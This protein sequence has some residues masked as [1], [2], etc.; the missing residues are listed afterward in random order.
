MIDTM[1]WYLT[2]SALAGPVI[3]VF[4]NTVTVDGPLT[5]TVEGETVPLRDDGSGSDREA[6]DGYWTGTLDGPPGLGK[7]QPLEVH[8]GVGNSWSGGVEWDGSTPQRGQVGLERDGT[9]IKPPFPSPAVVP[10]MRSDGET[11]SEPS[12]APISSSSSSSSSS[13]DDS[14]GG[15]GWLLAALGWG[16]FIASVLRQVRVKPSALPGMPSALK[17]GLHTIRASPDEASRLL[18]WLASQHRLILLGN[19]GAAVPAGTVFVPR[20]SDLG[21]ISALVE[22]LEGYGRPI[23][24]MVV[25]NATPG[26]ELAGG[27]TELPVFWVRSEHGEQSVGADGAPEPA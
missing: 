23:A 19:A 25:G 5:A 26:D 17:A 8:D 15:L 21:D 3:E 1:L 20:S 4:T 7:V 9:L 13:S 6:N 22:A 2:A 10:S 16:L 24:V 11:P 27:L 18:G 12:A 14:S